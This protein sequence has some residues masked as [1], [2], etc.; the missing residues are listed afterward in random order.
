MLA[1]TPEEAAELNYHRQNTRFLPEVPFPSSF[2]VSS[3]MD[4]VVSPAK[5]IILAVPSDRFRQNLRVIRDGISSGAIVI[6]TAKGLELPAGR[7][8]S[9][10]LEEE[11]LL[12]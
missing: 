12:S 11:L 7:R 2:T 3:D 9:Q 10:I 4:Q 6:S 8:M 5:L 1:R